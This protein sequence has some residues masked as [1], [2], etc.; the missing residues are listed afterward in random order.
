M[1]MTTKNPRNLVPWHEVR[2]SQK[3]AELTAS[4]QANG[5]I[6]A[7][8]I[9]ILGGQDD[10]AITGSHRIA[11][12][13]AADIDVPVIDLCDLLAEHGHSLD[14]IIAEWGDE[15]DA[16]VRLDEYLPADVVDTYGIDIH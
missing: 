15:Y 9:A 7:P 13:D 1:M 6:G 3:L 8:I 12:A 4:M 16:L 5:W 14:E 2:D 11:A 10:R